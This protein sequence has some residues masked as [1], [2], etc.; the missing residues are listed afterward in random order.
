[1]NLF[2]KLINYFTRDYT[3]NDKFH[4]SKLGFL[5]LFFER[6]NKIRNTNN[7]LGTVFR[8]S[9]WSDLKIAN[10]K[11]SLVTTWSRKFIIFILLILLLTCLGNTY[12]ISLYETF[13]QSSHF[14]SD[15][16]DR[17][18][19]AL[20]AL[21]V[22]IHNM[23]TR[24]QIN[25]PANQPHFYNIITPSQTHTT[26]RSAVKTQNILNNS[27][28]TTSPNFVDTALALTTTTNTLVD[29]STSN[30]TFE[31]KN[32][33]LSK[34]NTWLLDMTTSYPN[35]NSLHNAQV[36]KDSLLISDSWNA[37]KIQ[38]NLNGTDLAMLETVLLPITFNN[39]NAKELLNTAKEDRWFLHNSLLNE[40]FILN[41]NSYTQ[42]KRLLGSNI[43]NSSLASKN[44]WASSKIS[45]LS[46]LKELKN[47]SALQNN[48]GSSNL[49]STWTYTHNFLNP[50]LVNFEHF[51]TSR[52]WLVKK[53]F[54]TQQLKN[55][56]VYSTR[57]FNNSKGNLSDIPLLSTEFMTWP[58]SVSQDIH[59]NWTTLNIKK[60]INSTPNTFPSN[61]KND[62]I[63]LS[64]KN[65]DLLS[66]NSNNFLLQLTMSTLS[67]TQKLNYYSLVVNNEIENDSVILRFNHK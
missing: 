50:D 58:L 24:L 55:N 34:T 6:N 65:I 45:N 32:S 33:S 16:R 22:A 40:N 28:A 1:M 67:S 35:I 60:F 27:K 54:I 41:T 14:V 23:W 12:I 19:S 5:R 62:I 18:N 52:M 53:F 10:I 8:N 51:E 56:T 47:L 20:A 7:A 36:L 25:K 15:C 59:L 44:I 61:L 49:S 48:I 42:T 21:A 13:W 29:I 9:K 43:I 57:L 4:H 64:S 66:N 38:K 2:N 63:L 30:S 31:F 26:G 3:N 17:L 39:L 37:G 11:Q 46:T